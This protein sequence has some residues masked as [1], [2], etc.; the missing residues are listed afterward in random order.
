MKK[1]IAI[2][3]FLVI[4]VSL[5]AYNKND[6]TVEAMYSDVEKDLGHKIQKY[7]QNIVDV[8]YLYYYTQNNK[9]WTRKT[10]NSTVDKCVELCNDNTAVIAAKAGNFGENLLKSLIVTSKKAWKGFSNW[11]N[12]TAEEYDEEQKKK[13]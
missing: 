5:F 6:T 4:N 2:L 13:N 7:E 1:C 11:V 3:L 8:T 10:W 12:T 9:K